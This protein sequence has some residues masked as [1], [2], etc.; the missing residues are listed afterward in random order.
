MIRST[1][2]AGPQVLQVVST[3][4]EEPPQRMQK[5]RTALFLLKAREVHK[6]SQVSLD[7]LVADFTEMRRSST[8]YLESEINKI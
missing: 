1:T 6:I 8:Q 3:V 5:R 4:C 7:G 2:T